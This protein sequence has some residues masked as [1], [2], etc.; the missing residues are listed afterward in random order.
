M[1]IRRVLLES[2]APFD[3]AAPLPRA[4][5][6]DPAFFEADQ[7][8]F[9]ASWIPAAHESEIARPG[10]FRAVDVA[11]ERVVVVRG[12]DLEVHAFIDRCVHRGT[13]LTEGDGGVLAGLSITCPYHGLR[14]DLSGRVEA[15]S[16]V[17]L[18]IAGEARLPQV[19]TARCCGFVL[20]CLRPETAGCEDWMGALPAWLERASLH[21][22][23]LGRRRVQEVAPTGSSWW[24]TSRSHI[25]S[26]C[27]LGWR[28]SRRG[29]ARRA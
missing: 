3:E 24:R 1:E 26:A 9:A 20:V 15:G 10:Q 7:A 4:A 14:Y 21:A 5:Y 19:R 13:P 28:R 23:R 2:A 29:R 27:I 11:G 22:L 17:R 18:G 12:A 25:T 16:A 8:L 6:V